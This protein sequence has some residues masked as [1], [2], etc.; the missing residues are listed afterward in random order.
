MQ[1]LT[2]GL[3]QFDQAWENPSENKQALTNALSQSPRVDLLL[4]PEMFSTGFNMN[5][6]AVA[7]SWNNS[8][9]LSWLKTLSVEYKF[10]IFT[11]LMIEEGGKYFN[12][13]VFI[14]QGHL[15]TIYDKQHLFAFA[16]EDKV[17]NAG[18]Q[19]VVVPF[20]GWKICLQICFDLRF[21]ESARN[22]ATPSFDYDLLLYVANW[23]EKRIAH[24]DVL[25]LARAIENQAF[26]AAVNRVGMDNN[27][28]HYNGHSC[29]VNPD[30]AYSISPIN[31]KE[32]LFITQISSKTLLETRKSLPFLKER[33]QK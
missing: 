22:R 5:A 26:V 9:T 16:G 32:G 13:G 29:V 3:F 18:N 2:I 7:E 15:K 30:G 24:W 31:K 33:K 10:A 14:D 25:L 8:P 11:S 21:P 4:L 27:G 28:H 17:Y 20:L 12:R 1:D 19:S 23:P 6:P